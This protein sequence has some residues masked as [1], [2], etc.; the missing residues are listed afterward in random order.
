MVFICSENVNS[1]VKLKTSYSSE[2]QSNQIDFTH[3]V[4]L[5]FQF[6]K[7]SKSVLPKVVN[8]RS[9]PFDKTESQNIEN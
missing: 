3:F 9:I 1:G 6:P 2:S 4:D 5:L 8:D 7:Y